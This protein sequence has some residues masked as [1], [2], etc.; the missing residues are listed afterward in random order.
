MPWV[1]KSHRIKTDRG[2]GLAHRGGGLWGAVPE[3]LRAESL[4]APSGGGNG[5]WQALDRP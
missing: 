1:W 4:S 3:A 2:L 5:G